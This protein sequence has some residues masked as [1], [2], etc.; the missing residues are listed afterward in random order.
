MCVKRQ[1]GKR[2]ARPRHFLS[3]KNDKWQCV[4]GARPPPISTAPRARPLCSRRCAC[5][6]LPLWCGVCRARPLLSVPGALPVLGAV[7]ASCECEVP[8]LLP[9]SLLTCPGGGTGEAGKG[10]PH[11]TRVFVPV[12]RSAGPPASS[13][14]PSPPP[15]APPPPHTAR[16]VPPNTTTADTWTCWTRA[17]T[18]PPSGERD[19]GTARQAGDRV[20]PTLCLREGGEPTRT[21]PHLCILYICVCILHCDWGG[22]H[23]TILYTSYIHLL[24]CIHHIY[25]YIHLLYTSYIYI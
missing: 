1:H 20:R 4:S 18:P 21:P 14:P 7:C 24:H 10:S 16:G 23:T 2:F 13:S 22:I 12:I 3:R 6:T 19:G 8:L 5:Q 25:Y 11:M 9:A 15:R 17:S